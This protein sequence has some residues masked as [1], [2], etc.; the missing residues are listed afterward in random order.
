MMRSACLLFLCFF[1]ASASFRRVEVHRKPAEQKAKGAYDPYPAH[2]K[3]EDTY[4]IVKDKHETRHNDNTKTGDWGDEY[5]TDQPTTSHTGTLDGQ[6]TPKYPKMK[7]VVK[8]DHLPSPE[9][10]SR[11]GALSSQGYS[12]IS[13]LSASAALLLAH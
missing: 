7:G 1:L 6:K 8:G 4:K 11:S 12:L 10:A 13:I 2:D 3:Y 9:N 5:K